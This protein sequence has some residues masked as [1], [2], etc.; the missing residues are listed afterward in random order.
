VPAKPSLWLLLVLLGVAPG[1]SSVPASAAEGDVF[2]RGKEWCATT[3]PNHGTP[4]GFGPALDMGSPS[5]YRWPVL[6]PEDGRVRVFSRVGEDGWGN[7]V[8]WISSD[9]QERIH[10][11]HLDSIEATGEVRAG[12]MI[13]RVGDTGYSTTPHLHASRRFAG[14]PA[15]LL[16]GGRLLQAGDCRV[17]RGPAASAAPEIDERPGWLRRDALSRR[18]DADLRPGSGGFVPLHRGTGQRL[19]EAGSSTMSR[20]AR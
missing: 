1:L 14:R 16:L 17:S 19:G 9:G 2:P 11:A 10:M 15:P 18:A 20:R 4:E 5:D 3:H 13:G 7:S 12:D 6:A 8:L